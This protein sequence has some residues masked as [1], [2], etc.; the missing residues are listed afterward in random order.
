MPADQA[1]PLIIK[2]EKEKKNENFLTLQKIPIGM[3]CNTFFGMLEHLSGPYHY[4]SFEIY[5]AKH[6]TCAL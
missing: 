3:Y 1:N 6:V 4:F 5:H 2:G